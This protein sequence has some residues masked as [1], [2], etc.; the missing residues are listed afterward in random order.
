MYAKESM[1]FSAGRVRHTFRSKEITEKLWP[2]KDSDAGPTWELMYAIDSVREL[3][4]KVPDINAAVGYKPTNYIQGFTVLGQD[5]SDNVLNLLAPLEFEV[6]AELVIVADPDGGELPGF[7]PRDDSDYRATS[8]GHTQTK[9]RLRERIV[10]TYGTAAKEASFVPATTV[11]PRDLTLTRDGQEWLVEVKVIYKGNA[12][13]AVR[14]VVGQLFEYQHFHYPREQPP[15]L[16]GVCSESIGEAYTRFL[17]LHGIRSVR[18]VSGG[19]DGSALARSDGLA[20]S[21]AP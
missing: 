17:E 15:I 3:S 14:A 20:P 9:T 12:T 11:H 4:I 13:D 16:V 6:G 2:P 5:K 18:S 10:A 19:W 8:V 1:I 21:T 7:K